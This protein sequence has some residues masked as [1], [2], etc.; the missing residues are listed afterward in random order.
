MNQVCL[1]C[2][3][4]G[5]HHVCVKAVDMCQLFCSALPSNKGRSV[6][7]NISVHA[8][9][10]FILLLTVQD[11]MRTGNSASALRTC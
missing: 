5:L 8:T 11:T 7:I 2:W 9:Q 3:E 4:S 6:T 1:E 10:I